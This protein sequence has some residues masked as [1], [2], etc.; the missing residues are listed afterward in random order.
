MTPHRNMLPAKG[1][2]ASINTLQLNRD[3]I[4]HISLIVMV[5]V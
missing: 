1:V 3:L 5:C 2:I 4:T